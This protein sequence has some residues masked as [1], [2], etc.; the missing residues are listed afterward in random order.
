MNR[1]EMDRLRGLA[2]G[3]MV[4]HDRRGRA[5]FYTDSPQIV[6]NLLDEIARMKKAEGRI[7]EWCHVHGASLC[8][9]RYGAADTFGEGMRE[10]KRAV[11][12]VLDAH[13]DGTQYADEI[14]RL[15]AD[16]RVLRRAIDLLHA[17]SMPPADGKAGTML[18]FPGY[19]IDAASADLDK[20][21]GDE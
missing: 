17:A 14:A 12:G 11:L 2:E 7:V 3:A 1:E 10:A 13:D 21:E 9:E 18:A 8:P 5:L 15:E 6:V 19:W 16:N 20:E 4:G